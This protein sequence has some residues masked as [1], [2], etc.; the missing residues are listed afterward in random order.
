MAAN[1]G[2]RVDAVLDRIEQRGVK[3]GEKR[4]VEI[5]EKRGIDTGVALSVKVFKAVQA[6]TTDNKAIAEKCDCTVTQVQ[7]IRKAF[8]I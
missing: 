4:G 5:G 1:G 6:G 8:D 2:V 7:D 3:I